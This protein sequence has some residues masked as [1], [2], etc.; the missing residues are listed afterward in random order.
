MSG[1]DQRCQVL[2]E[3]RK[4]EKFGRALF[5]TPKIFGKT[6]TWKLKI[7][8][9][10]TKMMVVEILEKNYDKYN[11]YAFEKKCS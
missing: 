9:Y 5:I 3:V 11:A 7:E 2:R 8:S 10:N 4:M 6:I 1:S